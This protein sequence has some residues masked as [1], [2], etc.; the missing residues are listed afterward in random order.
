MSV[1]LWRNATVGA[2]EGA[3]APRVGLFN[4]AA[5]GVD[6]AAVKILGAALRE[7]GAPAR[8][9]GAD[10]L[11]DTGTVNRATLDVLVLPTGPACPVPALDTSEEFL[12]N[13]GELICLGGHPLMAEGRAWFGEKME[14]VLTTRQRD[15]RKTR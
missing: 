12:R 2:E 11:C 14:F 15:E 5:L 9:I 6:K 8:I 13:G 10:E 4:E 7:A 1:T 3:K